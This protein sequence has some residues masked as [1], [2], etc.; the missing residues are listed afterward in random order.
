VRPHSVHAQTTAA[1]VSAGAGRERVWAGAAVGVDV[2][3]CRLQL[4][5]VPNLAGRLSRAPAWGCAVTAQRRPGDDLDPTIFHPATF[6]LVAFADANSKWPVR[7]TEGE[8][9]A[10]SLPMLG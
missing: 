3:V 5:E 9:V 8:F 6:P 7:L 2:V 1:H 4:S 10:S